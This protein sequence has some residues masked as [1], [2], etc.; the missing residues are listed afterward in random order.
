MLLTIFLIFPPAIFRLGIL[1]TEL[2]AIHFAT[3]T[4]ALT[5]TAFAPAVFGIWILLAV[6][7]ALLAAVTGA[8]IPRALYTFIWV[9]T[10]PFLATPLT[11]GIVGILLTVESALLFADTTTGS[12][13]FLTLIGMLLTPLL[14]PAPAVLVVG[15][16]LTISAAL[17]ITSATT[18]TAAA[19]GALLT[20]RPIGMRRAM[21][22]PSGLALLAVSRIRTV[23]VTFFGT[24]TTTRSGHLFWRLKAVGLGIITAGRTVVGLLAIN[25]TFRK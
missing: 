18:G 7:L 6:P 12:G 10:T 4:R 14:P 16:G 1:L 20:F 15:M 3:L 11:I 17:L 22:F 9:V 23:G 24:T 25:L 19:A 13:V 21:L 5:G 2:P 8:V